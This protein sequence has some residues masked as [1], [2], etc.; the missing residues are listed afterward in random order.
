MNKNH[1]P[2]LFRLLPHSPCI[3]YKMASPKAPQNCTCF[4]HSCT[5]HQ[6]PTLILPL[7]R[8]TGSVLTHPEN[9]S[10]QNPAANQHFLR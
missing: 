1:D 6:E 5:S 2:G 9:T 8:I 3:Y 4:W 7:Q 10:V